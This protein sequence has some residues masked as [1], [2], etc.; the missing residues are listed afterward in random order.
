MICPTINIIGHYLV[1][2]IYSTI[3][4]TRGVKKCIPEEHHRANF[5]TIH[6]TNT[7]SVHFLT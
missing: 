1:K 6:L 4:S 3:C 2:K 7:I 5:L